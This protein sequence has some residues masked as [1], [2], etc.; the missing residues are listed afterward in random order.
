MVPKSCHTR[1][2]SLPFPDLGDAPR[3]ATNGRPSVSARARSTLARQCVVVDPRPPSLGDS[4][5]VRARHSRQLVAC[6]QLRGVDVI[7]ASF[8]RPLCKMSS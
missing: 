2:I 6:L 3:P 5:T 7:C 4:R 1:A 8:V